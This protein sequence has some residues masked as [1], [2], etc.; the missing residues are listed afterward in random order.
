M[1]AIELK[2][3]VLTLAVWLGVGVSMPLLL[4]DA[5]IDLLEFELLG[6]PR[7]VLRPSGVLSIQEYFPGGQTSVNPRKWIWDEVG[8]G[9]C[10]SIQCDDPTCQ[11]RSYFFNGQGVRVGRI[12]LLEEPCSLNRQSG[13]WQM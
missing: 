13:P 1:G 9:R 10:A 5:R 8:R 6:L 7:G 3:A 2:I 12:R 11:A 4:I